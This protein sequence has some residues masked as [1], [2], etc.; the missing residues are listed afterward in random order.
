MSILK[1]VIIN[2]NRLSRWLQRLGIC[3]G[4][5]H[6]YKAVAPKMLE[7]GNESFASKYLHF[8]CPDKFS[9]ITL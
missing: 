4:E 2:K 9:F 5:D 6:Y 7:I 8:H 1:S 3:M